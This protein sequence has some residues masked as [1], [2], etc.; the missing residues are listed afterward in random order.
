MELEYF[1]REIRPRLAA[2]DHVFGVADAMAKR[3]LLAGARCLLFPVQWEEPFGI[4]MIEAM[5]C[6]TPVV[7][8]RGGAVAEIV[9]DGVTGYVCEKPD[10][11]AAAIDRVGELDPLACRRRVAEH[12][13]AGKL[14]A[15]YEAVYRAARARMRAK[16]DPL[17]FLQT[18]YSGLDADLDRQYTSD[19]GLR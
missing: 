18:Q 13:N 3:E 5:V 4:V 1:E 12:F 10:E 9:Q 11:L 15:G 6:G 8:L 14:G 2:D 19:T 16:T 7:A 17:A